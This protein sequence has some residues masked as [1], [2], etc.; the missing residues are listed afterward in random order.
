LRATANLGQASTFFSPSSKPGAYNS[1][2]FQP[3][4]FRRSADYR[5]YPAQREAQRSAL[6]ARFQELQDLG[7]I[8]V[9]LGEP[10]LVFSVT[11][12]AN[13]VYRGYFELIGSP[14]PGRATNAATDTPTRKAQL[15]NSV[16]PK[17]LLTRLTDTPVAAPTA[18]SRA[19][20]PRGGSHR[21]AGFPAGAQVDPVTGLP[22]TTPGGASVQINPATGLPAAEDE[23]GPALQSPHAI[24]QTARE[25]NTQG[26]YDEALQRYLAYRE[27]GRIPRAGAP[28]ISALSDWIELGRKYPK[29]RQ[30]LIEIR[31]RDTR[32][33]SEGRGYADL[34]QEVAAIN[35][36]LQE[37]DATYVLFGSLG[38]S[39]PPLARQCYFYVESL[40]VKHG[41]YEMC[42]DYMG[43]PQRRYNLISQN[44][45]MRPGR[46]SVT[47]N[48]P[49][50]T[51]R[52]DPNGGTK[53]VPAD[54]LTPSMPTEAS[55][56]IEKSS[57]TWFVGEVGQLIEIL[58]GAGRQSDAEKIR[59]QALTVLDDER[60]KSAISDAAERVG[61]VRA[62]SGPASPKNA[63]RKPAPQRLTMVN[64][65]FAKPSASLG[66]WAP[67]LGP[68]EKPDLKNI[69][70]EAKDLMA[71]GSYEDAL[72]RHLWYF[73]H[74]LEYDNNERGVRLSF[75]LS[76]WIELGRR[77][78]KAR[79]A[80]VEI[81]DGATRE[82]VEGR[83]SARLFGDVTAINGHWGQEDATCALFKFVA[84]HD[85]ALA[86]Q[87]YRVAEP[88]LVK[89]GEYALCLGY[90]PDYQAKFEG[91]RKD[92]EQGRKWEE[93]ISGTHAKAA[94]VSPSTGLGSPEL[95]KFYD[96]NFVQEACRLIEV[97][98]ATGHTADAQKVRDQAL[99]L[100]PDSRLKSAVEDAKAR[101]RL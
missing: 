97:L 25:L 69:R 23:T 74:A 87:C 98:V 54:V 72:Q 19:D 26:R 5:D 2:W 33:F 90:I 93:K 57:E 45:V 42:L 40:L 4:A 64:T 67:S 8:P 83:G 59:D 30:A 88:L 49:G 94:W 73:K 89:N 71:K 44:P 62:S 21:S 60:L 35:G 91:L 34:F 1:A 31:D 100:L 82:L 27:Q 9:V 58:V 55:S 7:P 6:E 78:P 68:G 92:W 3:P 80:L 85:P 13:E 41:D 29:A 36:A 66:K 51:R 16:P 63:A 81:R 32:E 95:P 15:G 20:S 50:R 79:Q 12:K 24:L 43:D 101:T 53:S 52:P 22:I 77:Y 61:K 17:G 28:L 75:A 99:A 46:F 65:N 56:I 39:D 14:P 11:N 10:Y 86:K 84:D 38:Q 18:S 96:N 48:L 70:Q 47:R 37:T 76:D